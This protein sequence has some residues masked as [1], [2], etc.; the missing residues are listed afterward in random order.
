MNKGA[1]TTLLCP[2]CGSTFPIRRKQ[3]K[4]K[5]KFHHKKLYCIKCKKETNQIE[6]KDI[7]KFLGTLSFLVEDE[8]TEEEKTVIQLVKK[9][10]N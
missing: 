8:L 4:Q 2:E 6:I 3:G 9:R 5:K 10:G 1:P 7:D